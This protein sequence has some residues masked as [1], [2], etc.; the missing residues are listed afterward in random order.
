M[1]KHCHIKNIKTKYHHNYISQ[2]FSP[3]NTSGEGAHKTTIT[4]K[5]RTFVGVVMMVQKIG[6]RGKE[7][8]CVDLELNSI[9]AKNK[10][11]EK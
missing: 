5:K 11:N 4:L 7:L 10:K 3:V 2:P 1:T 8:H 6:I 9:I